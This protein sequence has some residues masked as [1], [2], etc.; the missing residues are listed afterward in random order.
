M[1]K[2]TP[3]R[4]VQLKDEAA[5]LA[6]AKGIKRT[7]ALAQIA[8]R[9]GF[10]SWEHLMT[11]AGGAGKVKEEIRQAKPVTP[12]QIKRAERRAK[13]NREGNDD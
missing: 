13:Y 4:I 8:Q 5:Q 9:E 1:D 6:T 7:A 11:A 10:K 2:L 12:G 3:D